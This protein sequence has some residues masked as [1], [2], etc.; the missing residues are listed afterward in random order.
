MTDLRLRISHA[1]PI[2]PIW[3]PAPSGAPW[4]PS[5]KP[6]DRL[7][8]AHLAGQTGSNF[9]A[10]ISGVVGAGLFVTLSELGADGFVPVATLGREYFV[11]DQTRHA[12]IGDKTGETFQLGDRVE[13]RLVEA[14][15]VSGGMRFEMVS[16]GRTGRPASP[17]RHVKRG[18]RPR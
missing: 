6:I 7:I 5:A 11:Y 13:V 16:E 3:Y 15:P 17:P 9:R 18:R 12:L 8:A 2:L 10:R 1:F 4:P 14:T